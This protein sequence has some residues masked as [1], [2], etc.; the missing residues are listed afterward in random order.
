MA[1]LVVNREGQLLRYEI[2]YD[3]FEAAITPRTGLFI[4]CNPHNPVGRSYT[5]EE[6]TCLAEICLRHNLIICADEIHCDLLLGNTSHVPLASLSPEFAERCI[7]LMAPSKTFNLAG[8]KCSFAIVPNRELRHRLILVTTGMALA[9]NVLGYAAA[10]AA[11]QDGADWLAAL[12]RYL[13]ANRDFLVDYVQEYLPDLSTTVPES[14]Y[15]AW[16]DCRETGIE[17]NP[18][19]FF[20]KQAQ[21]ALNDGSLFGPG[22][23]GF[24][25]LN[26][27]CPR[28][29]LA[30]A[31]ERMRAALVG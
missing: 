12:C 13:T 28:S 16:F 11:Y 15:L 23:E 19:Q 5:R 6:L 24:V 20:L 14:T 29:T 17:G 3:A 25:R 9:V 30:E 7:T 4:L 21:V 1:D 8:L 22:G 18:F 26:F 2:D 10:L 31:L 27:A